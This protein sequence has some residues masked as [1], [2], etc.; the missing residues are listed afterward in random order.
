MTKYEFIDDL[1]ELFK[2]LDGKSDD[3]KKHNLDRYVEYFLLNYKHTNTMKLSKLPILDR[4]GLLI[5][6]ALIIFAL[7]IATKEIFNF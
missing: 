5:A 1:I 4:I 2:K 6:I 3:I 7:S